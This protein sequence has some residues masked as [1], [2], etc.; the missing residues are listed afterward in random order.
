[1]R[2]EILEAVGLL[3]DYDSGPDLSA[4]SVP[5]AFRLPKMASEVLEDEARRLGISKSTLVRKALRAYMERP[6]A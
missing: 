1:M 5:W 6:N 2:E 3:A 4:R